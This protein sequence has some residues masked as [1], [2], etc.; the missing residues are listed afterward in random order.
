MRSD[1]GGFWNIINGQH[2]KPV[3]KLEIYHDSAWHDY[4]AY[5]ESIKF[6]QSISDQY[7]PGSLLGASSKTEIN[8]TMKDIGRNIYDLRAKVSFSFSGLNTWV[9][10][11]DG[12]IVAYSTTDMS[13][14]DFT[15]TDYGIS[16]GIQ[17]RLS[18]KVY[19][20][21][22]IDQLI[23]ELCSLIGL[24]AM[25]M[26]YSTI[27]IPVFWLDDEPVLDQILKL[28][29]LDG[30]YFYV[31]GTVGYYYSG[32]KWSGQSA[33][34]SLSY[35]TDYTGREIRYSLLNAFDK[36][37]VDERL[38]EK[39]KVAKVYSLPSVVRIP[40]NTTKPHR[41]KFSS[42]CW[43]TDSSWVWSIDYSQ[44]D[45]AGNNLSLQYDGNY[46]PLSAA[47]NGIGTTVFANGWNLSITNP[48]TTLDAYLNKFDIMAVP[49]VSA[50]LD[51]EESTGNDY[52]RVFHISDSEFIQSSYIARA[53]QKRFYD[54]FIATATTRPVIDIKGVKP[55]PL[56]VVGDIIN[57]D[58]T[59][60]LVTSIGWNTP[61]CAMD[62]SGLCLTNFYSQSGY[63][64]I[65]TTALGS[66]TGRMY[67]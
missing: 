21:Y 26:E 60:I 35:Q 47:R 54:R 62:V 50:P 16:N 18:T 3:L 38:F 27:V 44:T 64:I 20:N 32:S 52:T 25:I 43:V 15:I 57:V 24:T 28:A 12:K 49:M 56:L 58:G 23:T 66:T 46:D 13:F 8:C 41:I 61:E 40:A 22:R 67:Y 36:V 2:F 11:L 42:P 31:D 48:S 34:W 9:T 10:A 14:V 51:T 29:Q 5:V 6:N 7:G 33:N 63:F 19:E 37:I 53:I 65:G 55:N 39:G 1:P 45:S 4:S 17:S 30:G 59:D